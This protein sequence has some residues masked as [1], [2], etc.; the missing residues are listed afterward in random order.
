M[1]LV[2]YFLGS[3]KWAKHRVGTLM[4][5]DA[6]Y[7]FTL[8]DNVELLGVAHSKTGHPSRLPFQKRTDGKWVAPV[9][10]VPGESYAVFWQVF[11]KPKST[12]SVAFKRPGKSEQTIKKDWVLEEPDPSNPIFPSAK[13]R[14]GDIWYYV[15]K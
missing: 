4:A 10:I 9:R 8:T 5:V 1:D 15:A 3:L 2:R 14:G 13:M 12:V 6:E 7:V 11:G